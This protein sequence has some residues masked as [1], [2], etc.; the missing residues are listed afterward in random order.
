MPQVTP[1]TPEPLITLNA[2]TQMPSAKLQ[3]Q[4]NQE[5]PATTTPTSSPPSSE[6][7]TEDV[8]LEQKKLR[9]LLQREKQLV[10]ARKKLE[11]EQKDLEVQRAQSRQWQEAAELAKDNKL[12]ALAKLGITYDDLTQQILTGGNVPPAQIAKREA[13]Q[14][15]QEALE[16]YKKEQEENRQKNLQTQ[17]A[18]GLKHV[19][20]EIKYLVEANTEKYPLVKLDGA[21]EDIAKWIET[22]FH[23]TGRITPV[24][25]AIERWE[26]EALSGV[27]ELLKIDKIR[28][29][30]TSQDTRPTESQR[31]GVSQTLSQRATAPIPSPKPLTDAERRQRAMDAFYGRLVP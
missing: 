30:F 15:V 31:Q 21:Y 11:Q 12:E 23:R 29:R 13:Q 24:E 9:A 19:S 25:D 3:Q 8:P 2:N 14:T 5:N 17:V 20:N 7:K 16:A 4:Q 22:E 26:N 27:E 1:M 6:E 28:K 18:E 10:H